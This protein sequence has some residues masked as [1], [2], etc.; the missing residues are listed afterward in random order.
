[1][2]PAYPPVPTPAAGFSLARALRKTG[3]YLLFVLFGV[4]MV[5]G[6]LL[7]HGVMDAVHGVGAHAAG[8]NATSEEVAADQ[9][10]AGWPAFGLVTGKLI[11][12]GGAF[13][14]FTILRWLV[15]QLTHPTPSRWAK[16]EYS[17][18][19]DGL[20]SLDKFAVYGA[21][22]LNSVLLAAAALLFAALVQ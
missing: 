14:F 22:R 13:L 16:T 8:L 6:P 21:I 9:Q 19:F 1:M 20:E 7:L 2:L 4:A 11:T 18:A 10:A 15:Q 3:P 17:D 12:A 5:Y